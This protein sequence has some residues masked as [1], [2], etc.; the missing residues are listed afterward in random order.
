M[1]DRLRS[2]TGVDE[3]VTGKNGLVIEP[4]EEWIGI[5]RAE[6]DARDILRVAMGNL[7]DAEKLKPEYPH[8]M[9]AIG[10]THFIKGALIAEGVLV[11]EHSG[12]VAAHVR[13]LWPDDRTIADLLGDIQTYLGEPELSVPTG[14]VADAPATQPA[15]E[16]LLK[17][18]PNTLRRDAADAFKRAA[19]SFG[20]ARGGVEPRLKWPYDVLEA[21]AWEM[22]CRM[23]SGIQSDEP[24][25]D[26]ATEV[27]EA[28]ASGL[29]AVN[30]ALEG[31]RKD[32][33]Y[34]KPALAL[35]KTL[36]RY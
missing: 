31:G 2:G 36:E 22:R 5:V 30:R 33:A 6:R 32:S 12:K 8:T 19:K 27:K 18:D 9:E 15:E 13:K 26:P 29:E 3:A 7:E 21:Q 34:L 25:E 14:E 20:T 11:V 10:R 23:L 16:Q 28:A 1:K 24:S 4:R 17:A 35:K